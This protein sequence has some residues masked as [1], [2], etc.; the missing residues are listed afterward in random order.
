[1]SGFIGQANTEPFILS[2]DGFFPD[3]D[4]DALRASV[5]LNGD[6]SDLRLETSI[7]NAMLATNRELASRKANWQ[8]AGHATL[9]AVDPSE[10][11]GKN[12]LEQI[13]T[14]AIQALVA[15]ELAE[16]YRSFDATN[17]ATRQADDLRPTADDYRRD[18]RHAVRDL[19]GIAHATVELI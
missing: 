18:H 10:I 16:R 8:A 2:N 6:V 14:R 12:G 9:A 17:S 11:G 7:I 3:I 13:Y 19:L 5:R 1:M 15:A 4:A